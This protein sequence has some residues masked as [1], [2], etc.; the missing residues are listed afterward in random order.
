[1]I[2]Q[3]TKTAILNHVRKTGGALPRLRGPNQRERNLAAKA[4]LLVRT[5]KEFGA[6][7]RAAGWK[8]GMTR[9]RIAKRVTKATEATL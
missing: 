4:I 9:A 8:K 3:Q 1:M 6:E 5:D 7:V 2:Q